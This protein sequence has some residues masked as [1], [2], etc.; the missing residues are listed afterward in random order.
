MGFQYVKMNVFK[1]FFEKKIKKVCFCNINVAHVQ[2][3]TVLVGHSEL[4]NSLSPNVLR[5]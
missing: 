4:N 1:F 2:N 3:L 5:I